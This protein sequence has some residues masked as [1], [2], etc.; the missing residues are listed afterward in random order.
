MAA[1]RISLPLASRRLAGSDVEAIASLSSATSV[2][3]QFSATA[4]RGLRASAERRSRRLGEWPGGIAPPGS[5]RTRREPLDSPGSHRP[6][7]RA[8]AEPPV[9]EQV[10]LASKTSTRNLRALAG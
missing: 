3:T 2:D 4:L 6:A 8:R 1:E 5:L 10:G 9:S 7:V